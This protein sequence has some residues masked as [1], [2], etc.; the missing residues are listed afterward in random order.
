MSKEDLTVIS[1]G[2]SILIG[3]GKVEA[4]VTGVSITRSSEG[5]FFRYNVAWWD[6]NNRNEK[7]LESYEVQPVDGATA[8]VAIGFTRATT[9]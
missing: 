9:E 8:M 4:V 3:D 6:G 2:M 7:W 1:P 5:L